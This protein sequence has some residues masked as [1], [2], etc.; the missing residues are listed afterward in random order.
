MLGL[1]KK[2]FRL[3]SGLWRIIKVDN[4]GNEF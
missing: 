4:G 3:I 1:N 2:T